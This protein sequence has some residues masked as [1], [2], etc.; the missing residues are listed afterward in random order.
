MI[1]L[2]IVLPIYNVESYLECC[3]QSIISQNKFDEIE[4][5]L[6]DD[7]STD[8]S[9][10]IC[11]TYST[12]YK[13]IIVIHKE[14]GGLS[15]ARNCGLM[16]A[17]GKYIYFLDS[18]DYIEKNTIEFI[19]NEINNNF[20]DII[21]LDAQCVDEHGEYIEDKQEYVHKGV[22]NGIQYRG[23][24]F[25]KK[26]LMFD[27]NYL[28]PVWL[29]VYRRQY[30]IENQLWF[31]K[32]LLH[33]DEMWTPKVFLQ[34]NKIKHINKKL[35]CYRIREN[36]IMRNKNKSREKNVASTIYIFSTLIPYFNWVI[37]DQQLLILM[38]DNLAK[39]YLHAVIEWD[40]ENYPALYKK[41]NSVQ[42][43]KA[44]HSFKNKFRAFLLLLNKNLYSFCIKKIKLVALKK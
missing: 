33:E 9:P 16:N 35:Y 13:N 17:T 43:F 32:N 14:N 22:K 34:A 31:D 21:T 8:S 25:V 4:L 12:K 5:L 3:M 1:E 10:R 37:K 28:T 2:S 30:L 7:G 39:R 44:S 40:F 38:Q 41:V 20:L 19:L 42:L 24:E 23:E 36:S 29:G 6:I 18:D 27:K 11:D 15:D 26:Q